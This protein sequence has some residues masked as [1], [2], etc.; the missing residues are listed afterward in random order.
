[1]LTVG[2]VIAGGFHT[3]RTRPWAVAVWAVIYTAAAVAVG[4]MIRP[5]MGPMM[6]AGPSPD[7]QALSNMMSMM[8]SLFL[9]E[10]VY[11]V[12]I[13]ILLAAA[14]R[15][16]IRPDAPG[17]AYIRLGGDEVRVVALALFLFIA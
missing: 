13:L 6:L 17:F 12:F 10:L 1:M 3:L 2:T 16:V 9:V 5:L 14:M 7:P 4:L 15:A 8:S 11:L